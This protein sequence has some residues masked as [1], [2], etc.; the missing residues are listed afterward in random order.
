M[1]NDKV[2][3]WMMNNDIPVK[4]EW[5]IGKRMNDEY[6]Y[7]CGWMMNIYIDVDEWW[8]MQDGMRMNDE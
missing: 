3:G 6:L 1:N 4:C 7:R 8:I 2:W 5:M